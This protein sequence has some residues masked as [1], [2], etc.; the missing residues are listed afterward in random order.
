MKDIESGFIFLGQN[1]NGAEA[2]KIQKQVHKFYGFTP[3]DQLYFNWQYTDDIY[4][5]SKDSYK[6]AVHALDD[7]FDIRTLLK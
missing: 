1:W 2:V 3:V 5:E 7:I 6:D 4:D